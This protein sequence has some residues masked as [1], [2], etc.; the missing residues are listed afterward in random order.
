MLP[1]FSNV[2]IRDNGSDDGRKVAQHD[3]SVV[4]DGSEIFIKL[5]DISEVEG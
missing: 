4:E 2:I 1:E 5:Q 3:E